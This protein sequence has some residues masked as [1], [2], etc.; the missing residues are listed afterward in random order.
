MG[1][2]GTA[3]VRGCAVVGIEVV[4]AVMVAAVVII[5]EW[6]Y[7]CDSVACCGRQRGRK[8]LSFHKISAQ[9]VTH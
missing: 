9:R 5:V 1:N 2:G 8:E 6:Y 3:V 7:S 4:A